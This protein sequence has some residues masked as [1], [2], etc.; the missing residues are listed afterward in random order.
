MRSIAFTTLAF[1]LALAGCGGGSDAQV[2]S[3]VLK[4]GGDLQSG[5]VGE[6]LHEVLSVR[7]IGPAGDAVSGQVVSFIVATGGGVVSADSAVTDAAGEASVHWTL[8][9][10]AGAQ[11]LE[12]RAA[13]PG[14]PS[15]F[16]IFSATALPAPPSTMTLVSGDRQ[17]GERGRPLPTPI[18]VVVADRHGNPTPG[19]EVSFDPL[20]GGRTSP[21]KASTDAAGF[22]ATTWSLGTPLGS[23]SLRVRLASVTSVDVVAQATPSS[24][25][26]VTIVR[27][28]QQSVMQHTRPAVALEV[29][30][31]DIFGEPMA[32][33]TIEFSASPGSGYIDNLAP[34][35][36]TD[37][38]GIATWQ[39]GALHSAGQ[40]RILARTTGVT[41]LLV[42]FVLNVTPGGS[43][44]EGGFAIGLEHP[45]FDDG[46]LRVA[47][48]FRNGALQVP[49]PPPVV[50]FAYGHVDMIT[51]AVSMTE[52]LPGFRSQSYSGTFT[53]QPGGTV[54]GFG[55]WTAGD[56]ATG[57]TSRGNWWA[58]KVH[59]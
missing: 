2:A 51:G 20:D 54:T 14:G 4:L 44:F 8:G 56:I 41:P 31:T 10:G 32:G 39:G 18:A 12:V 36:T 34:L 1:L 15:P 58:L 23:Q 57:V 21:A 42:E 24:P 46:Q 30:I 5:I 45:I 17:V 38:A 25:Y 43:P 6:E 16:T 49:T 40:Q 22:A 13:N 59:D 47:F 48:T 27:G 19:V 3:E 35:S 26:S 7:A 33:V 11:S 28:D 53:V 37:S 52:F 50:G 29:R 9:T 55:S